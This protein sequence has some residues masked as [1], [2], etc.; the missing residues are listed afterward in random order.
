MRGLE[1]EESV[2][3][4]SQR[5]QLPLLKGDNQNQARELPFSVEGDELLVKTS[6]QHPG[7]PVPP[8]KRLSASTAGRVRAGGDWADNRSLE[9]VADEE[10]RAGG[11]CPHGLD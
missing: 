8:S 1:S 2:F 7:G 6:S 9:E 5:P 4:T 10:L 11:E 3:D